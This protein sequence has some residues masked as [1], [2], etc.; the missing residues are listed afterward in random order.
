MAVVAR[1]PTTSQ[2]PA[3]ALTG[4]ASTLRP[5]LSFEANLG[6]TRADVRYS[7]LA[8]GYAVHLADSGVYFVY[9]EA[10]S[11]GWLERLKRDLLARVLHVPRG[12]AAQAHTLAIE[13]AGARPALQW[14]AT[15]PT[16]GRSN[17]LRGNDSSRWQ[18]D[19]P[20]Y[21]RVSAQ[22]VYPGVDLTF[23]GSHGNLEYDFLVAPGGDPA[24]IRLRAQGAGTPRLAVSGA[25]EWGDG[26]NPVHLRPP[27]AYQDI[28]GQR[29]LVAAAYTLR[30]SEVTLQLGDYDATQLLVVDPV[31][32]FAALIGAN[33]NTTVPFG[34]S[35]DASGNV[36][37]AGTTCSSAF[38]STPGSLSVQG[39][40]SLLSNDCEDVFV[41]KLSPDGSSLIFSTF[42]GGARRDFGTRMAVDSAGAVFLTGVTTSTD[43]PV[44]AGSY[45][46]TAGGGICVTSSRRPV[47][48]TDA[49]VV[50][51]SADGSQ[52]LYAT[53]VGGSQFDGG[54]AI[55]IDAAGAAYVAGVSNSSNF[56]VIAGAPQTALGGGTCYLGTL[57]CFDAVVF[58]LSPNG[59]Q[60]LYSTYLG[61]NDNDF[62]SAIAVNAAGEAFAGGMAT[63]N[64]FGTTVGAYQTAH[65]VAAS[66]DDAFVVKLSADGRT[67]LYSTLLGGARSDWPLD[68]KIDASGNVLLAG[69]TTSPDFPTTSGAYQT[70]YG[71]PSNDTCV[72]ELSYPP[73]GDAFLAKFNAAGSALVFSTLLGGSDRDSAISMS[74]DAAQ[75]IWL[76]GAARSVN[77]PTT[78][79][80]YFDTQYGSG[81]LAQFSAD[82]RQLLFSTGLLP[83]N[84][85]AVGTVVSTPGNGYVY[86]TGQADISNTAAVTVN[87]FRAGN[88]GAFVMRFAAAGP[89]PA[90]QLTPASLVFPS[91]IDNQPIGSSSAA[92][93]ITMTNSGAGNLQAIIAFKQNAT[94]DFSQTNN[95]PVTLAPGANC[96]IAVTYT[97]IS[98][99]PV[100]GYLIVTGNAPG[101][102][103]VALTGR[104]NNPQGGAFLPA[105]LDFGG[106]AVGSSAPPLTAGLDLQ[107]VDQYPRV[108][109]VNIG[110]ANA[111]DFSV[112]LANCSI[113]SSCSISARFAPQTGATGTRTATVSV[114]T[115]AYASPQVLTLT[116][117]V[118]SG[119]ALRLSNS[120]VDL[121]NAT[122]GSPAPLG[123]VMLYNTGASTLTVS[124]IAASADFIFSG[125]SCGALPFKI[126][127]QASCSTEIQFQPSQLGRRDST[128]TFSSDSVVATPTLELLG[129]G[130]NANGPRLLVSGGHSYAFGNG[131][132]GTTYSVPAF[133][134]ILNRGNQSAN[135]VFSYQGDFVPVP[136]YTTCTATLVANSSCTLAVNFAPTAVGLRAGGVTITSDAPDSPL[137]LVLRGNGILIP[138]LRLSPAAISFGSYGIGVTSP[139][140]VVTVRNPGNGPL[141]LGA[142]TLSGPFSVSNGCAATLAPAASCTLTL[143]ATP[144]AVGA[145]TGQLQI[146]HDAQGFARV[147]PLSVKGI[148]GAGVNATPGFLN[149]GQQ[150]VRVPSAPRAVTL[151]NGGAS[152]LNISGLTVG[153]NYTQANNCGASLVS[154][155]SCT[156]DVSFLPASVSSPVTLD[157]NVIVAGNFVGS[158]L[159]VPLSG[160]GTVSTGAATTTAVAAAPSTAAQ[161]QAVSFTATVTSSAAGTPTG[162][163]NFLEGVTTLGS[164]TL[165]AQAAATF[166][167]S[168]LPVG[169]HT[170]TAQYLGDAN[171]SGSQSAV[172][173]VTVNA[174]AAA[175]DFTVSANPISLTVPAGQSATTALTLTP[176]NGSTQ[177]VSLSCGTLPA[178]TTCAFSPGSITLGGS[179][180][181]SVTLTLRTNTAL[182]LLSQVATVRSASFGGLLGLLLLF[183]RV[184][185][186]GLRRSAGLVVVSLALVACSSSGGSGG[187]IPP[188][189]SVTPPGSYPVVVTA[190]S[191]ATSRTLNLTLIVQ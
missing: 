2:G 179:Q 70:S 113:G 32:D 29:H 9:A 28:G 102:H 169:T 34:M 19:L 35:V 101:T 10:K 11:R 21:T 67:K 168:T 16:A 134:G 121:G 37:I 71:G 51:L 132:V 191:G 165:T 48:C 104:V 68:I 176:V 59:S 111:A 157:G 79:D 73:C 139:A 54:S 124:G 97:A 106:Q 6:Q 53:Y 22:A 13:F 76:T 78:A 93:T 164:G 87:G 182:A 141:N 110:G 42:L 131:Q 23:Y 109:A 173:S 26:E 46:R 4:A 184:H 85:Y 91:S 174:V 98:P 99:T 180:P 171:F 181:S 77:F 62:G 18:R 135:L 178:F 155:A 188:V 49:F 84:D 167:T 40:A 158:P 127:A 152:A 161:G 187:S 90:V 25:V 153:G 96:T 138:A 60:L 107:T 143:R 126:N 100:S 20:H 144:S 175:P 147:L 15:E 103:S 64:N 61:G 162:S 69:A 148:D 74:V 170:I 183:G 30:G 105:V 92:Q 172:A 41:S 63:S 81:F 55:A 7:A 123:G 140:V 36:F 38:P 12:R 119:P 24:Q 186:R 75:T 146:V 133:F 160:I 112:S 115:N 166:T 190:T 117:V 5:P 14:Q 66:Q 108:L 154:G 65:S 44:T 17:F 57:P 128:A 137:M 151:S 58:K 52:L 95:C 142:I 149:F 56:P 3:A 88:Y 125:G 1:G 39:G 86:V 150:P 45:Q 33:D 118:A 130:A 159:L 120:S 122:V 116:G 31:L 129:T 27:V 43:F 82:G 177:S 185:G 189:T 50:K 94:S 8:P 114:A 80:R 89:V 136:Q 72:P 83:I 47:P 145:A 163:V 156:V